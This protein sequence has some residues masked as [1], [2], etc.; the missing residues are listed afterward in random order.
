MD[1]PATG[2]V[3]SSL[4]LN[5]HGGTRYATLGSVDHRVSPPKDVEEEESPPPSHST[6][7]LYP[8]ETDRVIDGLRVDF[9]HKSDRRYALTDTVR[10]HRKDREVDRAKDR[11]DYS[12]AQL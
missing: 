2:R 8:H 11:A 9:E 6:H 12:T 4:I 1:I 10:K 7:H 3:K 5:C